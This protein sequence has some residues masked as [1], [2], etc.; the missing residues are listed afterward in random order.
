MKNWHQFLIQVK[1]SV[2]ISDVKRTAVTCFF[3]VFLVDAKNWS[4]FLT[5][6]KNWHQFLTQVKDSVIISDVKRT[7]VTCC[8]CCFL[9]LLFFCFVFFGG[10][11]ELVT[12]LYTC[13]ELAPNP[14]T[15]EDFSCNF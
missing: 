3:C 4:K 2:K 1:N 5:P 13:E 14:N 6:V 10:C 7:A 12:I 9:L 8:C 11:K 15:S